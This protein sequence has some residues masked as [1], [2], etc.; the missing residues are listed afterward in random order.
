[1]KKP[2]NFD[3]V[4]NTSIWWFAPEVGKQVEGMI[5]PSDFKR[6]D[7]AENLY[8]CIFII[9][10]QQSDEYKNMT[11]RLLLEIWWDR[12][13]IVVHCVQEGFGDEGIV[14][15]TLNFTKDNMSSYRVFVKFLNQIGVRYSH[16]FWG[17]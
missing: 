10:P 1:M 7:L 15:D 13:L 16:K 9:D 3:K 11:H 5:I 17:K 12:E 14:I 8:S 6:D 4:Y 2:K